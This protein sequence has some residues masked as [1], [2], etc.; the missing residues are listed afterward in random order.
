SVI[1]S[2]AQFA[3][4]VPLQ[5]MWPTRSCSQEGHNRPS[6]SLRTSE[7]EWAVSVERWSLAAPS[8]SPLS[9]PLKNGRAAHPRHCPQFGGDGAFPDGADPDIFRAAGDDPSCD[10]AVAI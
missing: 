10:F 7:Q 5:G 3:T 4:A 8:N 2:S 6:G 9:R 1:S